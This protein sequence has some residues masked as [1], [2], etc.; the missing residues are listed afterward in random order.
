MVKQVCDTAGQKCHW[1]IRPNQSMRW[2]S[3]IKVYLAITACCLAVAVFF[4]LHGFWPVLP[5]AGLEVIVLGGAFYVCMVRSEQREIVS[6]NA[7][8]LTVEKGRRKPQ[9]HW[10]CP[11]AWARINLERSRIAWYPSR[12]SVSFKSEQVE[13]GSFLNEQERCLLAA[14]LQQAVRHSAVTD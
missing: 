6:V 7:D 5:F 10:E 1:L 8:R 4:A 2:Q 9:E 12:L 14:E 3:A 13:I 11:R